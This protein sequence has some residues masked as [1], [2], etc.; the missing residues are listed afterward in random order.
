MN[1]ITKLLLRSPPLFAGYC[2]ALL[3]WLMSLFIVVN[4]DYHI[5]WPTYG[6]PTFN[7][8]TLVYHLPLAL[9]GFFTAVIFW[10]W[11]NGIKRNLSL[12]RG[13]LSGLLI[14]FLIPVFY[15]LFGVI[16]S[17]IMSNTHP[18]LDSAVFL[19][20]MALY[21]TGWYATLIGLAAGLLFTY[22]LRR[23]AGA[24]TA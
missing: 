17:A 9:I 2:T 13:A 20:G 24:I 23:T 1:N 7:W 4:G 18:P 16:M 22:F 10:S 12:L 19:I 14:G 6:I 3:T 5:S 21:L 8:Q 11:I 15:M